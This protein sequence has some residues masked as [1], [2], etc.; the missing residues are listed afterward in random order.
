MTSSESGTHKYSD[1]C[2]ELLRKVKNG[3]EYTLE[4]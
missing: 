1:A 4:I 3:E 2:I